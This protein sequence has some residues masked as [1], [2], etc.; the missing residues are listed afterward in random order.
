[1]ACELLVIHLSVAKAVLDDKATTDRSVTFKG[2]KYVLEQLHFHHGNAR[3][4]GSE[5]AVDNV[6]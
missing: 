3:N 4:K 6:Q 1:M 5:H 2:Q